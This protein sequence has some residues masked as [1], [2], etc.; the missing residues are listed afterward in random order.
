MSLQFVVAISRKSITN[1][2]T[3][4]IPAGYYHLVAGDFQ[5]NTEHPPLVKMWAAIPLLFIQPREPKSPENI[6]DDFAQRSA[7]VE[8]QFWFANQTQFLRIGFWTRLMMIPLT[9]LLGVV[10]FLFTRALSNS[11]AA[12]VAVFLYSLEPTVLAHGRVVHTDLPAALGYLLFFFALFQYHQAPTQRRAILLG[13]VTALALLTKY[14]MVILF[15]LLVLY[16]LLLVWSN[17]RDSVWLK[18]LLIHVVTVTAIVILII[19]SVYFFRHDQ[20]S[21]PDRRWLVSTSQ[22]YSGAIDH[23]VAALGHVIPT[24]YL[25]GVYKV[26]IHN[27][28]G[29]PAFLLGHYSN[30]GWRYYF[31]VAFALKTTMPF[32]ILSLLALAWAIFQIAARRRINLLWVLVPFLIY[33]AVSISGSIN[34]GIRHFLPAFPFLFILGGIVLSEIMKSPRRNVGIGVTVVLIGWMSFEVVRAFPNYTP[35]MN[36]LASG[37]NWRYLSDSNVEWGDDVNTLAAYLKSHGE[38]RVRGALSAGWITLPLYGIEY[39]SLA[40]PVEQQV[41]TRYVAIGASFL[42]GSTVPSFE[43]DGK[44]IS[45]SERVNLFQSYRNRTPEAVFGGSIYLFRER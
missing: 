17:R 27:H 10:I 11:T 8:Q 3:A 32:L 40:P 16:T 20:L 43:V 4:H 28:Y 21:D 38:R 24:Y 35:Y 12:L 39:V 42:N 45:D 7:V 25:F 5:L 26:A 23:S 2:E 6:N 41:D 34:I 19:N 18:K 37:P 13:I 30:D 29:H 31:P 9:V 1:D 14:S 15:P 33:L 36:Q 22:P 44:L